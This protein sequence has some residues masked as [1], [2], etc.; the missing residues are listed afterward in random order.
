MATTTGKVPIPTM[1]RTDT[2]RFGG[3]QRT[4][5]N[6]F[7]NVGTMRFG[8]EY[9]R[10]GSPRSYRG[11]GRPSFAS[12]D[13]FSALANMRR[14]TEAAGRRAWGRSG[15]PPPGRRRPSLSMM[16]YGDRVPGTNILSTGFGS[17]RP[18]TLAIRRFSSR[19]LS[20][21]MPGRPALGGLTQNPRWS[22][23]GGETFGRTGAFSGGFG[24]YGAR[25]GQMGMRPTV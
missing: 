23:R 4:G 16:A 24:T 1:R 19:W 17:T 25:A 14:H 13:P 12:R 15:S 10:A 2:A 7:S 3:I 9:M 6:S 22:G 11:G 5:Y 18:K 8:Q 20:P 21:S